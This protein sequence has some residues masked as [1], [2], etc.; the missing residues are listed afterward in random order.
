MAWLGLAW[1]GFSPPPLPSCFPFFLEACSGWG[2]TK[3]QSARETKRAKDAG[4]LRGVRELPRCPAPVASW[5]L[6]V[7]A[8]PELPL[9]PASAKGNEYSSA[10]V[11]RRVHAGGGLGAAWPGRSGRPDQTR[12]DDI[13][14]VEFEFPLRSNT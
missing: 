9:P 14:L 6:P 8:R 13:K 7:V 12:P 11:Y 3:A 1:L 4:R 10:C 2:R 5:L